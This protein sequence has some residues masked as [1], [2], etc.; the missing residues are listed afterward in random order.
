MEIIVLLL[1]T[2]ALITRHQGIIS[3]EPGI[4]SPDVILRRFLASLLCTTTCCTPAVAAI[5]DCLQHQMHVKSS[6]FGKISMFVLGTRIRT[7]PAE[8]FT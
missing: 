6:W 7:P 3:E 4:N 5:T 1:D 8:E 2:I